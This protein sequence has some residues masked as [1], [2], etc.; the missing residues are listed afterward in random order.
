MQRSMPR[1][2]SAGQPRTYRI[3]GADIWEFLL[4]EYGLDPIHVANSWSE[5][6]IWA[7]L[8]AR[9]R[10]VAQSLG[11]QTAA[12]VSSISHL[13]GISYTDLRTTEVDSHASP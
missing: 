11:V 3:E 1:Q 10:R 8:A 5:E 2:S 7:I 12:G 9:G 4:D 13:R 6:M